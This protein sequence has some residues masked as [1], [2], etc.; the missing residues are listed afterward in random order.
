MHVSPILW[1]RKAF[2]LLVD[3]ATEHVK[4]PFLFTLEMLVDA[5]QEKAIFHCLSGEVHARSCLANTNTFLR[6]RCT[7]FTS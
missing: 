3:R 2:I 6:T 5:L 7:Y 1:Y 4:Y